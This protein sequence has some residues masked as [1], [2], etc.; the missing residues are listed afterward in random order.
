MA[1]QSFKLSR[2][3]EGH[4]QDVRAVCSFEAGDA[5]R[6][7]VCCTS[8]RDQSVKVWAPF[9][10]NILQNTLFGHE[11][12]VASLATVKNALD[13]STTIASGGNDKI[14]NIWDLKTGSPIL[15]LIGHEDAVVSISTAADGSLISG[16]W[17][18]TARIWRGTE[19]LH[20]LRGHEH[21]VWSVL[22]LPNGDIATASADKTIRIWRGAQCV[23]VLKKHTEAVRSLCLVPGIGFL[24]CGNDGLIVLW[25]YDGQILQE[26]AESHNSFVYG[27][28]YNEKTGEWLSVSEDRTLKIWKGET[29]VQSIVHPG[30][31]WACCALP[32]GDV[33]TG[34]SDKI[35]RVW[36][37]QPERMATTELLQL[38]EQSISSQSLPSGTL[39]DIQLDKLGN[40]AELNTPG[41]K[42]QQVK[43]IRNEGNAEAYQWSAAENRWIKIG[44]V[45][46]AKSSN[47]KQV[48]YGKEYDYIFD[49]DTGDG[50]MRKL[51]Y[52]NTDNP[53]S[54]AQD[55]LWKEDLNQ[56][57]LDQ[58]AQFIIKNAQPVTLGAA[59]PTQQY[60]DPYTGSSGY[61]PPNMATSAPQTQKKYKHI[62]LE[63]VVKFDNAQFPAIKSKIVEF[64]AQLQQQNSPVALSEQDLVNLSGIFD[65]LS[66]TSRYHATSSS[67]EQ[68]RVLLKLLKWP[69]AQRF[70]GFDL[71]RMFV[72]HP[73]AA[74]RLAEVPK[75]WEVLREAGGESA[76]APNRIM[77]LRTVANSARWSL[78]HPFLVTN[79]EQILQFAANA[80]H[81]DN[82]NVRT[83]AIT[84]VL[85]LAVVISQF[86]GADKLQ[87]LNILKEVRLFA[88]RCRQTDYCRL[89]NK[90]RKR[91]VCIERL[92]RSE[93]SDGMILIVTTR[94]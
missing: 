64:N 41:Q 4:K 45:M 3:L 49:I 74:K 69:D 94:S 23:N 83:A 73:D 2:N 66:Q 50:I 13:G 53:Y 43:I 14:I 32:N 71:L 15:T 48:L 1:S 36:T 42:D 5:D 56:H 24:S 81:S 27:I 39:G 35:A 67:D 89:F 63:L 77:A 47:A 9:T 38:Y 10:Q 76:S 11:H 68:V 88:R 90:K 79:Q 86:Q 62:P 30:S 29:C 16:S 75:L 85:N 34:C 60:R 6:T 31:V 55:F 65:L 78:F 12:F 80:V 22:G 84:I 18:K 8:S 17:D 44:E 20:V 46:D 70:P 26:I 58:V 57:Y 59:P 28:N 37:R 54:V 72:L 92:L 93:L 91:K 33:L 40:I 52:N 87:S 25:S 82:K 61:V 51:G 19:C 21:A 7:I